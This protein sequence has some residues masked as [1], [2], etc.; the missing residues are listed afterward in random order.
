M[1]KKSRKIFLYRDLSR[2]KYHFTLFKQMVNPYIV[3]SIRERNDKIQ[4]HR[5]SNS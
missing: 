1:K 2:P 3:C 4:C 5:Q